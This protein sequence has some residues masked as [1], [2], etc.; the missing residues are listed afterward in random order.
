MGLAPIGCAPRY[1]W[2]YSSKNGE[3]IKEIND[4]VMEFN[5]AMRYM[6]EE[7]VHE[8]GDYNITFCDVFEAS[9]D[10][11]KNREQYGK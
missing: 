2:Q 11:M 8:L 1:L 5:F 10:I 4:M 9:M 7:L 3:C 6:V